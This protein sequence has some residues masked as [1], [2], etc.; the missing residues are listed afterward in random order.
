MTTN[1]TDG[2]IK[3]PKINTES[4]NI[5]ANH[6][7]PFWASLFETNQIAILLISGVFE[8]AYVQI[9]VNNKKIKVLFPK[10]P[11]RTDENEKF[12]KNASAKMQSKLGQS[13]PIVNQRIK[14]PT[15][16][17]ITPIAS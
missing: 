8:R 3:H 7:P 4:Q 5:M 15:N 13:M 17:P 11:A 2:D 14:L 12:S 16:I 10:L 6:Q 9:N 1:K